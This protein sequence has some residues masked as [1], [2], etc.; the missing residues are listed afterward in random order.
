M[1]HADAIARHAHSLG[2]DAVGFAR[3]DV[4]LT[5]DVARY[6]EF[7]DRGMHGD[8]GYLAEHRGVRARV[9]TSAI[10]QGARTVVCL[11][12][13]Y[14]RGDAEQ[15]DPPLMRRVARYARGRDYHGFV[16][17]RLQKLAAFVRG[18]GEAVAAR[19]LCDT[20][21]VLERAWASR[22]GLGFVGK[23]GMLIIPGQGSYCLLGEVVTTLELGRYGTPIGERC[24]S[25]RAC[26]DAC[27]TD[28]F[29]AA[30][31]LDPRRCIAY[32]TI[33]AR[34][35]PPPELWPAMGEHLFGCDDCQQVCPYNHIGPPPPAQTRPFE[36]LE[37]WQTLSLEQL[38]EL[39][40]AGWR[41][42]TQGSPLR[43]ATRLGM[44]RNALML[45]AA[46]VRRTTDEHARSLIVAAQMHAD[47]DI[48]AIA[49]ELVAQLDV[50]QL[51]EAQLD[52]AQ[53]DEAQLDEAQLDEAQL[54]EAQPFRPGMLK[55]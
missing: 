41:T 16:R 30:F 35:S 45:A 51:D 26:L 1:N 12:R 52:V 10:L 18:L 5:T 54:D 39:D 53:L 38:L 50:A 13:R 19:A 23:N 7:V 3:A 48:R 25:C 36:P 28:A 11:A 4:E 21:P 37:R 24:G 44:A 55:P 27:P 34:S 8:M 9:D 43:R 17:K 46:R 20:A 31:V 33:E 32:A 15:S 40:E 47:A 42:L 22:A 49:A 29:D 14:D 6:T 2:F